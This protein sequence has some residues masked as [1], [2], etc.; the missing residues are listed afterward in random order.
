MIRR[1][2]DIFL[3]ARWRRSHGTALA[4]AGQPDQ[5]CVAILLFERSKSNYLTIADAAA[6]LTNAQFLPCDSAHEVAMADHLVAQR[7]AF[8]KP[9]RH[10]VNAPVHP[11]FVLTDTSP[12]VVIEVLGMAG[13]P[14]YVTRMAAKRQHYRAASVPFVE[15][16][17]PAQPLSAVRLPSPVGT[18]SEA[19]HAG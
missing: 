11:D 6:M 4:G 3:L 14:E 15:W 16:N 9:L 19:T 13:N 7:R 17:A 1:H 18:A 2:R 8:R 12:E 10:I 5:R